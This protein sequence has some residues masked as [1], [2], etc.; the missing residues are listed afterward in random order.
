MSTKMLLILPLAVASLAGCAGSDTSQPSSQT[1]LQCANLS[2]AAYLECQR[3]IEPASR[4]ADPD[5]KM[6][7][8][9]PRASGNFGGM[10]S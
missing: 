9:K 7:K 8:P 4:T 1:S 6:V 5:F 10:G 2:G 3:N